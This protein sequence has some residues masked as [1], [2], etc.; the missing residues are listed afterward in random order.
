VYRGAAQNRGEATEESG[1][2]HN[3]DLHFLFCPVFGLFKEGINGLDSLQCRM[4]GWLMNNEL[5]II[6]KETVVT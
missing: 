4:I 5:E 3:L 1:K 6:W 2:I